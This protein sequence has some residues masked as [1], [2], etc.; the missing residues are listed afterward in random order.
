MSCCRVSFLSNKFTQCS[1]PKSQ[2]QCHE[3]SRKLLVPTMHSKDILLQAKGDHLDRVHLDQMVHEMI[4]RGSCSSRAVA[5][6]RPR[7]SKLGLKGP[8]EGYSNDLMRQQLRRPGRGPVGQI[9]GLLSWKIYSTRELE[10]SSKT[11]LI[12]IAGPKIV[13]ALKH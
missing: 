4:R 10:N 7:A 8:S 2:R 5:Q 6:Q 1:I 9:E 11:K 13:K 3:C 12:Y